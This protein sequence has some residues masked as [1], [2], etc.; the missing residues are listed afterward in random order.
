[1]KKDSIFLKRWNPFLARRLKSPFF[2]R[3]ETAS[4]FIFQEYFRVWPPE[5][6]RISERLQH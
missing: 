1:M 5:N 4:P 3:L 2:M 6:P